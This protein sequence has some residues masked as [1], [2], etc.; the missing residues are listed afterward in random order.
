MLIHVSHTKT[1]QRYLITQRYLVTNCNYQQVTKVM[2]YVREY[3][4]MNKQRTSI[5][6]ADTMLPRT[7]VRVFP[8]EHLMGWVRKKKTP[9]DT[10]LL[11]VLRD[12]ATQ[13]CFA[14]M[15]WQNRKTHTHTRLRVPTNI[16]LIKSS[17]QLFLIALTHLYTSLHRGLISW[18]SNAHQLIRPKQQ[19]FARMGRHKR[20]SHS[21]HHHTG[22]PGTLVRALHRGMHKIPESILL[23]YD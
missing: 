9:A 11:L 5:H 12:Q 18:W 10:M 15:V 8:R 17:Q 13:Q 21:C 23:A 1:S 4:H 2:F 7:C 20:K 3:T 6:D 14:R 19:C 16:I 22:A